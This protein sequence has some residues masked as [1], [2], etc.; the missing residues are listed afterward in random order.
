MKKQNYEKPIA[1]F[2][3][4]YSEKDINSD[5]SG[6]GGT[7]GNLNGVIGGSDL[8]DEIPEGVE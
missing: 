7:T 2:I 8:G 5:M 1:S 3:A 6:Y 4:F